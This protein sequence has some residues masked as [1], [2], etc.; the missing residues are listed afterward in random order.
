MTAITEP[1]TFVGRSDAARQIDRDITVAAASDAKVLVTG[2]TGVGKDVVARVLHQRSA[3]RHAPLGV[4]NCAGL[5]DTLLE[6]ELFGHVRGSFTGA[7]RDKAGLL[8]AAD[9]GTAFLDEAGEMS[10]RMQGVLLRFLETG[11]VQ[12][13]GCERAARR[14]NVRVVAATNRD[15]DAQ[16][17]SGAFRE[18]LY[19]RLNVIRIH[20]PALRDRREDVPLLFTHFMDTFGRQYGLASRALP[21]EAE[22]RLLAHRWPGNVRELKNLVERLLVQ[23]P[24]EPVRVEDLRLENG[25]SRGARPT[26]GASSSAG[27]PDRDD[28]VARLMASLLDEGASFWDVVHAPFMSRDL[29]RDQLRSV[30]RAGLELTSGNY[31]MLVELFNMAPGDYKRFLGFLRKHECQVP[32]HGFRGLRPKLARVTDLVAREEY[33]EAA[34]M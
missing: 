33:R 18:D 3:R 23:A 10:L 15:L 22:T 31:R 19:Y 5:P 29:S 26:A 8:E 20:V 21:A 28:P 12:R 14:V 4:I 25:A 27:E 30:V 9:R 17:A 7:V 11:E 1:L 16:I 2:E 13:V 34:G 6:S 24:G 32:F